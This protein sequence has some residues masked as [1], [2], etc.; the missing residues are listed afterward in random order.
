MS[1]YVH[2][3]SEIFTNINNLTEM[4]KNRFLI[5]VVFLLVSLTAAG[6]KGAIKGKVFDG[7]FPLPGAIVQLNGT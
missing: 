6:Q 5:Y 4:E 2:F 7:A 3:C 1:I